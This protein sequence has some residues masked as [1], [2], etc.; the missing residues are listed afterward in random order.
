MASNQDVFS[1]IADLSDEEVQNFVYILRHGWPRIRAGE[2]ID[3]VVTE[4]LSQK[5]AMMQPRD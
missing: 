5:G 2:D 1:Q 3:S 4:L